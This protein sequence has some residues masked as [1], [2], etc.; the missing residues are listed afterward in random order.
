[1]V[2]VLVAMI[3]YPFEGDVALANTDFVKLLGEISAM[4]AGR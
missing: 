1:M 3:D 4:L 2:L